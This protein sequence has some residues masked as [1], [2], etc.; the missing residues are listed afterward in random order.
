LIDA[1]AAAVA[2]LVGALPGP[3]TRHGPYEEGTGRAS[4]WGPLLEA[5][6]RIG[7]SAVPA[8][9]E[10]SG[11]P[12]PDVR[13]WAARLLGELPTQD[14]ARAIARRLLDADKIV[15]RAARFAASAVLQERSPG[16][17]LRS[18]LSEIACRTAEALETRHAAI[19][20]MAELRE[21]RAIAELTPLLNDDNPSIV[22]RAHWA[23]VV[24]ARTDLGTDALGWTTWWQENF[25]RHRVEWLI[26]ALMHESPDIRRA[27]G[28]ELK[29][30]TKEYFGYYD[31]LPED[32]RL[33]AQNRYR[34]WWETKGKARFHW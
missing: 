18:E 34:Q 5:I 10:R 24:L 15:R 16:K 33:A 13:A 11:D 31:D 2:P 9:A 26:D 25:S 12:N 19:E 30:L 22:K 20:A 23:L 6:V 3:I 1:G 32:E 17:A 28:E 8:L 14:G 29:S 7:P 4:H 21:G 27:A